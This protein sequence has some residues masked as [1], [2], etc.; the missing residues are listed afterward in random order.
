[1]TKTIWRA[2]VVRSF[3][4]CLG[5]SRFVVTKQPIGELR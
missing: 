2:V 1:M 5:I 3:A 4:W